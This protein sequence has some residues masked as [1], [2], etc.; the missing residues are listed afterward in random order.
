MNRDCALLHGSAKLTGAAGPCQN[1]NLTML[2]IAVAA[3]ICAAFRAQETAGASVAPIENGRA[4]LERQPTAD[5]FFSVR[6]QPTRS[7][8]SASDT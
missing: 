4:L 7:L 6:I 8:M 2:D 5:Y 3:V 1:G